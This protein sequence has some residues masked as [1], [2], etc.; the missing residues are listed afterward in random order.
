MSTKP[1]SDNNRE[2]YSIQKGIEEDELR[3]DYIK[4]KKLNSR[5][6]FDF[7]DLDSIFSVAV[8]NRDLF[9]TI[10]LSKDKTDKLQEYMNRWVKKYVNGTRNPPSKKEARPRGT[11]TDPAL[12]VILRAVKG[13]PQEKLDEGEEYHIL[14]MSAENIRGHLL[15][16]YI[17]KRTHGYGL[18]WCMG[19][20][21]KAVDFCNSDGSFLLQV[22]SSFNSENARSHEGGKREDPE[23]TPITKWFR[24]NKMKDDDGKLSPKFEWPSLNNLVWEHKT[25][26]LSLKP[27]MSEEDFQEFLKEKAEANHKLISDP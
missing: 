4:A 17:A 1:K 7:T 21:L 6:H 16:E 8:K 22:K 26:D 14:F 3:K 19:P 2:K 20:V 10:S 25:T 13:Y 24:L 23:K 15:E 11:C 18:L 5:H 12:K 27:S 9:I